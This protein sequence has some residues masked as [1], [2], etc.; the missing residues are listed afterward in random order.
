MLPVQRIISGGQT[1]ADRAALD[2]AIQHGYQ[3][4]GWAPSGR[5][6]EDGPI[7]L[8]YQLTELADGGYRQRTKRNVA[9][10]N[11]TLI[12]NVGALDGGSLATQF[13]ALRLGRA[14]F[15][16]QLDAGTMDNTAMRLTQWLQVHDVRTL[17]V[18]G[19]RESKRP[20]IY[21]LTYKLLE[22]ASTRQS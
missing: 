3:H 12:V 6:A 20:G 9:E 7:P 11:G 5:G 14:C 17:N 16:A 10:S 19:P 22:M 8:K 13:F 4:G 2:F 15:L 1:G 18:A 21:D